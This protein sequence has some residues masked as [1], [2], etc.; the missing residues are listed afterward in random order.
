MRKNLIIHPFL[1]GWFPVLFLFTQNLGRIIWTEIIAPLFII[2]FFCALVWFLLN[3]PIRNVRK[4]GMITSLFITSLF[5]CSCAASL[6]PLND[7]NLGLIFLIFFI[8][9]S[10]LVVKTRQNLNDITH[11]LNLVAIFLVAWQLIGI[12]VGINPF[13]VASGSSQK[14]GVDVAG[15]SGP[16]V[17]PTIYYIILDMYGSEDTLRRV[18]SYDNT[19]FLNFLRKKHFYV[20]DRSRSNY[21]T[22]DL[23]LASSLNFDYLDPKKINPSESISALLNLIHGNKVA[24]FLNSRGYTI[25]TY[26]TM[27]SFGHF[28]KDNINIRTRTGYTEFQEELL[29]L[30]RLKYLERKI[31]VS[32]RELHRLKLLFIFDYLDDALVMRKP[33]FVFAHILCP[34]PPFVFDRNGK[35]VHEDTKFE[36]ADKWQNIGSAEFRKEYAEQLMFVNKEVESMLV[37]VL[38]KLKGPSV[39][40]LQGDHGPNSTGSLDDVNTIDVRER[41]GNLNAYYF[42][43]YDYSRLYDTITPVNSFRVVFN[44]Y[45]HTNYN[46]LPD[47]SYWPIPSWDHVRRFLDVTNLANEK[48]G[49]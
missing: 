28:S 46:L 23:S 34:H 13:A 27:Q 2:T 49:N 25:I 14:G 30:T 8:I 16:I 38:S 42:S 6:F 31:D 3:I 47:N 35:L 11:A 4:S 33:I 9:L 32:E 21:P 5:F 37:S 40:I 45:F 22:T 29:R 41:M 19:D 39:I 44:K 17:R 43:D 36:Y 12:I 1:F 7:R 10:L 15:E 24:E 20:V 26:S 48:N 18:Y